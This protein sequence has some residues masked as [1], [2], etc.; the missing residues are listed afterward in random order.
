VI[1]QKALKC[2]KMSSFF[3][4]AFL[5]KSASTKVVH[6]LGLNLEIAL[7]SSFALHFKFAMNKLKTGL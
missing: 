3:T 6:H 2:D 1:I 7:N 5:S 4:A